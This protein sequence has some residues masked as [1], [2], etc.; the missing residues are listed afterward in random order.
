MKRD[1][2]ITSIDILLGVVELVSMIVINI[3]ESKCNASAFV[4]AIT[5]LAA[6]L[7]FFVATL[8]SKLT[9]FY[10]ENPFESSPLVVNCQP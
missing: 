5:L 10:E 8:E 1:F 6:V 7:I 9:E 4:I 2:E 3:F